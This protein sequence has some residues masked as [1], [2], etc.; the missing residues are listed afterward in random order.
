VRNV[1][2]NLSVS[3]DNCSITR[4]ERQVLLLLQQGARRGLS[5]AYLAYLTSEV[6]AVLRCH[7]AIHG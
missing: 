4:V 7:Y 1:V 5:V 2:V 3:I 6:T